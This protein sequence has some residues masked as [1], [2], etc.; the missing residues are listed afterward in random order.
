MGGTE[1]M[2][3]HLIPNFDGEEFR[4]SLICMNS[5]SILTEE[6]KRAGIEVIHLNADSPISF[7]GTFRLY[8]C[9]RSVRAD[10]I[11]SYGLRANLMARMAALLAGVP[12]VLT[13]QR[14][15]EDWKTWYHVLLEKLTSFLVDMY[16]GNSHACTE[17]L[18]RRERIPRR[19]LMTIHNG[20]DF[21][22]GA[23]LDRR[24]SSLRHKYHLDDLPGPL[25]GTVGRLNPVKGQEVLIHAAKRVLHDRDDVRFVMIGDDQWDGTIQKLLKKEGLEDRILLPGYDVDVPAWL[26]CLDIYVQPSHSEGLPVATTEAMSMGLPVVATDVGGT[27][28]VVKNGITGILVPRADPEAMARAILNLLADE[29]LRHRF[30]EAGKERAIR[31]FSSSRML[32]QYRQIVRQLVMRKRRVSV[33]L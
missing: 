27:R 1:R 14:G 3:T 20:I 9:L 13:G 29:K 33:S 19:K 4:S 21:L 10:A 24:V 16:I 31:Y 30:G 32:K 18:A 6:W 11:F 22:P 28:E 23:D 26:A 8:R 12:V 2:L 17:T 25:V 15:I 7:S 5:P